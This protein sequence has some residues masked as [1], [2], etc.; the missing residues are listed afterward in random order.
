MVSPSKVTTS[1]PSSPGQRAGRPGVPWVLPTSWAE[2]SMEGRE[3]GR[4]VLGGEECLGTS[5]GLGPFP[6]VVYAREA[7][8]LASAN[9]LTCL[10]Y[11]ASSF[12]RPE[13]F[14]SEMVIRV[15]LPRAVL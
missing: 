2:N 13:F 10:G 7:P 1:K 3:E 11:V 15:P 4:L 5:G 6:T 12:H 9:R 14:F 8:S